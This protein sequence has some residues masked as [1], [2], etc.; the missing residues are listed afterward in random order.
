MNF[1]YKTIDCYFKFKTRFTTDKLVRKNLTKLEQ[2]IILD[3][4][5]NTI[6]NTQKLI[7]AVYYSVHV[8]TNTE[9]YVEAIN[10]LSNNKRHLVA[11][12]EN[13]VD[14]CNYYVLSISNNIAILH[15]I[16][17]NDTEWFRKYISTTYKLP[18]STIERLIIVSPYEFQDNSVNIN[19]SIF[20]DSNDISI[21]Q[22]EDFYKELENNIFNF[23]SN[24]S[25]INTYIDTAVLDLNETAIAW[26]Y[27]KN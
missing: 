5:M 10:V 7:D 25:D 2:R 19:I 27:N 15:D 4:I 13:T 3:A 12:G 1:N 14:N 26:K 9:E 20:T 22:V 8:V 18:N 21:T 6:T 23:Y 17:I 11:L 24:N 16:N